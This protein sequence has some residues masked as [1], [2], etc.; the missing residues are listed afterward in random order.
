MLFIVALSPLAV[1]GQTQPATV[2]ATRAADTVVE[3]DPVKLTSEALKRFDVRTENVKAH[4]L[5]ASFHA[6]ARVALNQ[7]TTVKVGAV[8]SGRIVEAKV[9]AG[10]TVNRGD[11]LLI[12]ESPELGEA[13]S[14]YLTRK[15][16]LAVAGSNL[17]VAKSSYERAKQLLEKSEGIP[18]TEVLK[19]E[20]ELRA[21][22]GAQRA[23]AGAATAAENK[24]K[25]LGM[26]IEAIAALETSGIDTSY[27]VRA[28]QSGCVVERSVTLGELVKPENDS[29]LILSDL[30]NLW[31]LI[32]VP[33][34]SIADVGKGS[35]VRVSFPALKGKTIEGVISYIA[36]RLDEATRTVP[37]RVEIKPGDLTVLSGMFA[38]AEV[39]PPT[40]GATVLSVPDAAV[41]TIDGSPSVFVPVRGVPGAFVARR[42]RLGPPVGG[43]FPVLGGLREGEPFV[44]TGSFILK[45]EL[46]KGAVQEE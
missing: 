4:R 33:E 8:V 34:A 3:S 44:A 23:A 22:E 19:R 13:Q 15:T 20:G 6:P 7:E 9:R 46:G 17:Q 10:D 39:F 31:V 1:K 35:K 42:V 30:S 11:A 37:V 26:K 18:L 43:M 45:A 32:D 27:T 14:E 12:I 25:I 41:Q 2:S 38:E 40:A 36:S 21:A 29:L 24:L 28:P 16:E 5:T